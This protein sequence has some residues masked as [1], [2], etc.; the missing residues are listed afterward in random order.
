MTDVPNGFHINLKKPPVEGGSLVLSCL[1][2]KFLYKDIA[3]LLPRTVSNHTRVRKAANKEYSIDLTFIIKNV[4]LEH[5]GTYSCR[6]R[7]IYTGEEVL[8]K[9]DVTVRGEH[10]NKKAVF[11]RIHKFKSTRNDCTTQHNIKHKGLTK[12]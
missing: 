11:S 5:S 9:K 8:Q 2:N 1:A 7:N 10:C 12:K 3:W 4:S 6:A